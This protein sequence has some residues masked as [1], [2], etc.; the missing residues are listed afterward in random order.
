[1]S[2]KKSQTDD[3]KSDIL[4]KPTVFTLLLILGMIFF[5]LMLL[6]G[7][8]VG[9]FYYLDKEDEDRQSRSQ[10][11]NYSG[12]MYESGD[13]FDSVDG[14]NTCSCE[15]GSVSCTEMACV[16]DES[17]LEPN[18]KFVLNRDENS[19]ASSLDVN[20]AGGP[21][22]RL[23]FQEKYGRDFMID[24]PELIVYDVD[25]YFYF[26]I[27]PMGCS[28]GADTSCISVMGQVSEDY[29]ILGGIWKLDMVSGEFDH[30]Y[31][32]E[33]YQNINT[34]TVS[35]DSVTAIGERQYWIDIKY[36]EY[37]PYN[38]DQ[39]E[40]VVTLVLNTSDGIVTQSS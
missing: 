27:F 39:N 19:N 36:Y 13:T 12:K 20:G 31:S 2:S 10:V 22:G 30:I 6:I 5:V 25:V 24:T 34:S 28:D 8:G 18:I 33:K 23:D 40:V 11:C 26:Q 21:L 37:N 1:M 3:L 17:T 32:F 9:L 15:K 35:I 38:N 16:E 29:L 4:S 14:C 7:F